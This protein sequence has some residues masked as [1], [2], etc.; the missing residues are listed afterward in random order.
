MAIQ[1]VKTTSNFLFRLIKSLTPSE[2][3]YFKLYVNR[4][5]QKDNYLLLFEKID[6]Q[7]TY[8]EVLLL[9]KLRGESLVKYFPSAKKR[10]KKLILDSLFEYKINGKNSGFRFDRANSDA[11]TLLGKGFPKEATKLISKTKQEIKYIQANETSLPTLLSLIG[12]EWV[13]IDYQ[14]T[15]QIDS[16]Y[17][18]EMEVL[19]QLSEFHFYRWAHNKV[20][21]TYT[22]HGLNE[23]QL[24]PLFKEI[25]ANS[26]FRNKKEPEGFLSK[27]YYLD[28]WAMYYQL[29]ENHQMIFVYR[30]KSMKLINEKLLGSNRQDC[31]VVIN[32]C[33]ASLS[34]RNFEAY[35]KGIEKIRYWEQK[36]KDLEI[37]KMLYY[38][39]SLL[40][41]EQF[42][43]KK[44]WMGGIQY[45][46]STIAPKLTP[47]SKQLPDYQ[48]VEIS[49][50]IV[51]LCMVDAQYEKVLDWASPFIKMRHSFSKNHLLMIHCLYCIAHYELNNWRLL[52]SLI[53]SIQQYLK[54]KDMLHPLAKSFLD[55][56]KELSFSVDEQSIRAKAKNLHNQFN[57][58]RDATSYLIHID[59]ASELIMC[60]LESKIQ[61][62]PF[63]VLLEERYW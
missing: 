11:Y 4:K 33:F 56:I 20:F 50:F 3:R 35:E 37:R 43:L 57:A 22:Q 58:Q 1:T 46:E 53:P 13:N 47:D 7:K 62:R 54:R 29:I 39:L 61:Q 45:A 30:Q 55:W 15:A 27:K 38:Y 52:E 32:Y 34:I 23:K 17:Q 2:K 24:L 28:V 44:N 6:K 9:K 26:L 41:I 59:F 60:W 48:K 21:S 12:V 40:E 5:Q 10:L 49:Q 18:Q 51:C 8:D 42:M 31:A 36:T 25:L 14:D 16:L 19:Q 63:G